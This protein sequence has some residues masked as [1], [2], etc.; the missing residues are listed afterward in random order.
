M[1][2][3]RSEIVKSFKK[4]LDTD[5]VIEYLQTFKSRSNRFAIPFYND[6]LVEVCTRRKDLIQEQVVDEID[7]ILKQTDSIKIFY[8]KFLESEHL[9]RLYNECDKL[10]DGVHNKESFEYLNLRGNLYA[11]YGSNFFERAMESYAGALD[12]TRIEQYQSRIY[13]NMAHLIHRHH[14][15]SDYETAIDYC[16]RSI[17]LRSTVRFV[18]PSAL[19]LALRIELANMGDIHVLV[20]KHREDYGLTNYETREILKQLNDEPKKRSFREYS[21][22]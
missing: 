12:A 8:A 17:A 13:N 15:K 20:E 11:H 19:M 14:R 18:Y 22:L 1:F 6:I 2:K 9:K 10:L 21:A 16:K 3:A 4:L 5:R 7:S